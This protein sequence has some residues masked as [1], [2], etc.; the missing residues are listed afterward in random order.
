MAFRDRRDDRDKTVANFFLDQLHLH[1]GHIPDVTE[2]HRVA[3]VVHN[4]FFAHEHR[5]TRKALGFSFRGG[6]GVAHVLIDDFIQ[7]LLHDG[8]RRGVSHPVSVDEICF[9]ARGLHGLGDR[10]AAAVHDHDVDAA[11]RE[12]RDVVGDAGAGHGIGIIHKTPSI[13]NDKRGATKI[14]NVG[15]CFEQHLGLSGYFS[16]VH[17]SS[18]RAANS[19]SKV[20]KSERSVHCFIFEKATKAR[21]ARISTKNFSHDAQEPNTSSWCLAPISRFPIATHTAR[22][23]PPRRR[24]QRAFVSARHGSISC[25]ARRRNLR[26]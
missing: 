8:D 3:F 2:V 20:E 16:D 11:R 15:E 10:L 4:K 6:D 25:R 1:F 22:G 23:S 17:D 12:K 19:R 26:R 5:V 13:F 24:Y 7:G 9:Q 14:L 21:A 18:K